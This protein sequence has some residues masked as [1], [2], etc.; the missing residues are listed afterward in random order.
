MVERK[1]G[2]GEIAEI[3]QVRIDPKYKSPEE[4][5]AWK[6][7]GVSTD[8]KEL[9]RLSTHES[10]LVR[11]QVARNAYRSKDAS[12]RLSE[13]DDISVRVAALHTFRREE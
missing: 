6:I 7:A 5:A 8:S 10:A 13:D 9:D 4:Y 11:V 2:R 3:M 1:L 12:E